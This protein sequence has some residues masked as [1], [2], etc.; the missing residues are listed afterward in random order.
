M[1]RFIRYT[2]PKFAKENPQIEIT[3][4]PRPKQHPCI[5]GHYITGKTKTI[6]VPNL[7]KEQILSKVQELKNHDGKKLKRVLKPVSSI[8]ESVRGVWSGLHGHQISVGL[9]G[10]KL[11]SKK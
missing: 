2:L 11:K 10:L 9:E 1:N 7:E 3:I 4:S 8:N 5:Q 6:P